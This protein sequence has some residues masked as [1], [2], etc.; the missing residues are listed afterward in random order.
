MANVI[1]TSVHNSLPSNAKTTTLNTI[2][3]GLVHTTFTD[4]ELSEFVKDLNELV[5]TLNELHPRTKK[6]FVTTSPYDT[7]ISVRLDGCDKTLYAALCVIG[8]P[9]SENTIKLNK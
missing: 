2:M 6:L 7:S 3:R 4:A 1:I 9:Y 8:K 5:D